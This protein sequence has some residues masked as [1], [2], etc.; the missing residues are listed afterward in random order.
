MNIVALHGFLGLETDWNL[1]CHT[2]NLYS[3]SW[4]NLWETA[5]QIKP[6]KEKSFLMGY[7]LGGR[8]ALHVLVND[9]SKWAGGI[10][11]SAHPGLKTKLERKARLKKDQHWAERFKNENW[12]TL[13][14]AWN[15]QP[16]FKDSIVIQRNEKDYDRI[17]LS[18]MLL[19]G[20]LGI[21]E[22][23][24]SQI[25]QLQIP[26]FWIAGEK[27]LPYVQI[28]K[29]ME[30]LHRYSKSIILPNSGHRFALDDTVL[31]NKK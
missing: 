29:E 3:L 24:R 25:K 11:I 26:L 28:S 30:Q 15:A 17:I 21:Q 9:P 10:I 18:K 23:L 4:N 14:N 22:D 2:R 1:P 13:I 6:E 16:I 20:S 7:S 5:S 19:N 8:L 27:D 12:D 31:P